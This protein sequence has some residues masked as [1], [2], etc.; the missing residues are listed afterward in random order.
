VRTG[1]SDFPN[2]DRVWDL[3]QT[4]FFRADGLYNS[5]SNAAYLPPWAR[6]QGIGVLEKHKGNVHYHLLLDCLDPD[7]QF[8]RSLFLLEMFDNV[9]KH[10]DDLRD[11]RWQREAWEL[12][13][14]QGGWAE[15]L[16]W[17][18][19]SSILTPLAPAGTAMVQL[20]RTDEDRDTVCRYITKTWN[21]STG[22]L[23]DRKTVRCYDPT[24]DWKELSEFHSE[25]GHHRPA[26]CSRID[27]ATGT[28]TLNLDKPLLWKQEG[29]V[30]R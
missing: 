25:M 2:A 3:V 12:I 4:V 19:T 23:A 13:V 21:D 20:V 27:P 5:I 26:R 1:S 17:T 18:R 29:R 24:H 10:R 30:V 22:T 9:A 28:V 7:D 14:A 15:D 16:L 6:F 8:L 11:E